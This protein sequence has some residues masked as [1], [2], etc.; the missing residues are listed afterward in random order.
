MYIAVYQYISY[1]AYILMKS[2]NAC[3]IRFRSTVQETSLNCRTTNQKKKK[4][5]LRKLLR[6]FVLHYILFQYV[7]ITLDYL[8]YQGKISSKK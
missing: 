6:K 3:F 7:H 4:N 5:M 8:T 2:R 1:L